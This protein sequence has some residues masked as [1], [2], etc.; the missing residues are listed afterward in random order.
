MRLVLQL[1]LL[2]SAVGTLYGSAVLSRVPD[3]G[4]HLKLR[5]DK[6][7]ASALSNLA[8]TPSPRFV[9]RGQNYRVVI[10]DTLVLPCEV[11]N[12]GTYVLLWR[13]GASVL[14]ADK[15]MVTRDS[16]FRLVDGFNLEI[17]DVMPQDAGDYVCQIG[18]GEN[19]DQIHTVEILVPPSIRTS[20][21]SGQLTARKGGTI[22]LECKASG[23]PVPSI[24]WSRKDNSLPT[25]EKAMEGFSITLEKVDR[26]QAG[27]YQCTANNGVG[28]PV[29]VDMQLDVL[30]P[31][32][33]EVERSWVHTGEGYDAQ[34]VCIVHGE[35]APNV[36]WYQDS[37]PLE[38]TER[39]LM[40]TRGNKHT[41]TLKEVQASDFGNY[42]CVAENSLGR[43]KKYME[44]SGRPSPA[45]FRSTPF[46]RAKDS[47]NLTWVVESYPPLL[48]VR[49]LY[50]KIMM[51]DT[52]QR[53]GK[54]HEVI[55]HPPK[56][57]T[58][59]HMMSYNIRGLEAASVFE[60]IAQAKNEYG[61]NEVSDLYQFYTR[62]PG[63]DLYDYPSEPSLE[64]M[65]LVAASH[66]T[67][68]SSFGCNAILIAAISCIWY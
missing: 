30:Y 48:E 13:R 41:L 7:L 67:V 27:V 9:T 25:G 66:T 24:L 31:P 22:T 54:W 60:A 37:F 68:T 16:R 3:G 43:A 53:H 42:S 28:D 18:D 23:N 46:S 64:D 15:I 35:P 14:T 52:H 50:R 36:V 45:Q 10:G 62:G 44:L 33:I 6:N 56:G 65:E 57:E 26:H 38:P 2:F 55:L 58:F 59:S 8:P 19:R 51:N 12:L 20:P 34:L 29:T 21:A 63:E 5:E 4:D 61:W 32:E 17:S 49:L 47:Y 39:K 1:T 40:E 11:E